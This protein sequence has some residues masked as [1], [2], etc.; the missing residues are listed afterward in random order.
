MEG[1]FKYIRELVV[2]EKVDRERL[3]IQNVVSDLRK[4]IKKDMA[5]IYG[6]LSSQLNGIV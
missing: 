2:T 1:I 4:G 5:E 6:G 3:E